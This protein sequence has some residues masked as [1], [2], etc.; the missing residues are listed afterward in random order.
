MVTSR[1]RWYSNNEFTVM[2]DDDNG[3]SIIDKESS[4]HWIDS[5]VQVIG[6]LIQ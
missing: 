5:S 1:V 2:A 4:S 6:G 3:F